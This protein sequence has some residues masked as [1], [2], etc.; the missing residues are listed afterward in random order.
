M[1]INGGKAHATFKHKT[2]QTQTL[3]YTGKH[4]S[5]N[6]QQKCSLQDLHVDDLNAYAIFNP[7]NNSFTLERITT[8]I[9]GLRS[10]NVVSMKKSAPAP[11]DE[12]A[13]CDERLG[14]SYK[15]AVRCTGACKLV[16]HLKCL[17]IS[18][19]P[20]QWVCMPCGSKKK[21]GIKSQVSQR[22]KTAENGDDSVK[23][24]K[25]SPSPAS[26]ATANKSVSKSSK[27]KLRRVNDD[28]VDPEEEEEEEEEEED[29]D[30]Y[31]VS[32]NNINDHVLT[33]RAEGSSEGS[34][35]DQGSEG[36][37]SGEE[38]EGSQGPH[39]SLT[40][41]LATVPSPLPSPP[42][43]K[44]AK[45]SPTELN[46]FNN[47]RNSSNSSQ[48]LP[49]NTSRLRPGQARNLQNKNANRSNNPH[50]KL[51]KA[52]A[53]VSSTRSIGLTALVR[54]CFVS[55]CNSNFPSYSSL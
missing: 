45:S 21:K 53:P 44:Q 17:G 16:F 43:F 19:A 46:V 24:R 37:D 26:S 9:S 23:K 35:S 12:C 1:H 33:G 18:T 22:L 52:A 14:R 40:Q 39:L 50:N 29:D 36:S 27:K 41:E 55:V 31:E 8:Q 13:E 4:E 51:T 30:D 28:D 32:S 42:S 11:T 38:S 34:D 2:Q 48:G 49:L 15:Q 7:E 5:R 25:R 10:D 54:T 20:N 6:Q 3:R 47:F